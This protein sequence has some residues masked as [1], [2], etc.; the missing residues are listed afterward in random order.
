MPSPD[1]RGG[2]DFRGRLWQIRGIFPGLVG[3]AYRSGFG[4]IVRVILEG[5][6]GG[7]VG[8]AGWYAYK[9]GMIKT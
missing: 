4:S 7:A 1:A 5:G 8:A 9:T 2:F 3:V 6:I